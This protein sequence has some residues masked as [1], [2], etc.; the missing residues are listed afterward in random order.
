M[1]D[2]GSRLNGTE[3]KTMKTLAARSLLGFLLLLSC[4]AAGP[5]TA[6]NRHALVIG[7]DTYDNLPPHKQLRKAVND[8][9]AVAATL[10][11]LGFEVVKAEDIDRPTFTKLWQEFLDRIGKDDIAAFYFSGHGVQ[12]QGANHLLLR[13]LPRVEPGQ[14]ARLRR[15]SIDFDSLLADFCLSCGEVGRNR[16]AE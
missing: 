5:A 2:A 12:L 4:L 3:C 11:T 15:Q 9:R 7:V 8:A 6:A 13:D 1:A 16:I 10:R 14:Y